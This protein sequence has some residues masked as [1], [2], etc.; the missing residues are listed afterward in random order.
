MHLRLPDQ[1][2]PVTIKHIFEPSTM[3]V[4]LLTSFQ[5]GPPASFGVR[6]GDAAVLKIYDRCFAEDL[7]RRHWASSY[8]PELEAAYVDDLLR[9][10]LGSLNLPVTGLT[11]KSSVMLAS[12]R[13]RASKSRWSGSTT[14]NV[15]SML[16]LRRQVIR[17]IQMKQR[18]RKKQMMTKKQ[19]KREAQK[20]RRRNR[21]E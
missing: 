7:R 1:N 18:S 10:P 15:R 17:M 13:S 16:L 19:M 9:R 4:V 20:N 3:A 2:L 12:R 6:Q 8:T 21:G 11:T 14:L 5:N